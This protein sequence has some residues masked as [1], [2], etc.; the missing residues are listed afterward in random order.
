M[1]QPTLDYILRNA[2]EFIAS[3]V[4]GTVIGYQNSRLRIEDKFG[5]SSELNKL[6][7]ATLLTFVTDPV[8]IGLSLVNIGSQTDII[9]ATQGDI[10]SI[11]GWYVGFHLGKLI[12]K[13]LEKR[14]AHKH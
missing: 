6:G 9:K 1:D 10:G 14:Y 11:A 2:S 4:V 7:H 12:N 5:D 3:S 8:M 13:G